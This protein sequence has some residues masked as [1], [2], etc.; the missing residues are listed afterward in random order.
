MT[1]H[2]PYRSI[3]LFRMLLAAT[4][5]LFAVPNAGFSQSLDT[6]TLSGTVTDPE[7]AVVVGAEVELVDTATNQSRKQITNNAGQYLFSAVPPGIYTLTV[8]MPGFRQAVIPS[9]KVEVAKSYTIDVTLEVGEMV[10][11]VEV[12]AGVGVELQ[13]TDATVGNVIGG[14]VLQV[15]TNLKR[16]ATTLLLF[17]PTVMP[18]QGVS[19]LAGGQ[20]AGARSDQ[21]TFLLDGGE[22]TSNVEGTGGYNTG[23]AGEPRAVIPTPVESLEEFR[24]TTNNPTATFGRSAGGQVMMVTKRGTNEIHG[25]AYWYHQNDNL[26]ANTWDFNRTGVKKPELKDNRFGF[27]LGGPLIKNKTFLFGHYEGRR[28][29]RFSTITRLVPTETLRQGILRF[30]DATGNIVSYDLTTAALCGDGTQLCDPRGLGISPVVRAL[31]NLLPA[32]NDP[33]L[34]DGLNTIGF[35][36]AA[37]TALNE[38]FAVVRLDHNFSQNWRFMASYRYARTDE[39]DTSQIDIAGLVSG[40][41]GKAV[42]VAAKP[43]EPRYVVAGLTGSLTPRLTNDF[44]FSWYRHWW[45]WQRTSPF[46]QVPG[47]RGALQL[48]GE[49]GLVDEPINIDTQ[50]A[51]SRVWNGRVTVISDNLTWVRGAHTIQLGGRFS[52]DN[53]IHSRNDKVIGSLSSLVYFVDAAGAATIPDTARPPTCSDTVTTNCLTAGDV[54][55]W[56]SLYAAVLGI[57]DNA[58]ILITR[59]SQLRPKPLGTPLRVDTTTRSFDLFASDTWR[60]GPSFTVTYGLSWSVQRPITERDGLQTVMIFKENGQI[61]EGDDYFQRRREAALKGEIF[62]PEL[63]FVPI[64]QSGRSRP[65]DTDWNNLGPRIAAAWNPSFRSGW[66]GRLFGDGRT[67]FRGGYSLTYDRLN[68][69]GLVMIPILGVGFGQTITC[70]GPRIDGTCAGSNDPSNAFRIGVDGDTV[71]LPPAPEGKVPIEVSTPFGEILSFQID[72]GLKV[73]ESHTIDFTIQRELP[74]NMLLE[75]GYVGRFGRNLQQSVDLNAAPFFHI[76]PASGQSFAEAFDAVATALRT[77]QP[78]TPQPWFENLLFPGAT[79]SLAANFTSQ[80]INGAVTSMWRTG[81]DLRARLANGLQPFN[82]LQMLINWLRV[83]GGRSNYHAGFI[84]LRKRMSHGLFF[85]INYTFSHSLDQLG[86]NQ[87]FI[88]TNASPFDFDINYGPSLFDRRHTLSALWLYEL[89]FG[90]GRRFSTGRWADKVFGGWYISGIFTAN[91]GLPLCVA[92]GGGVWG[93]GSFNTQCAIPV[94]KPRFGNSVH[95][96]VAGSGGV[97]TTG[98]PAQGGSGLNLFAD[99]EAVFNNF[100]RA[101]ISQD[102][103]DGRGVLRGQARWNMDLSLGKRT[104][105][106]ETVA[107]RFSFDFANVFNHVEFEDPDLTLQNPSTFGVLRS[108][109]NQPRFIQFGLRFEF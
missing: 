46:P 14:E 31:W 13:T 71:P 21:N 4:L 2:L 90:R 75:M 102:R 29:P 52:N 72:T 27:S 18:G 33:T 77:G 28:F 64:N 58:S 97:G 19:T 53:T 43:L 35:R 91:S 12:T 47:T 3:S 66:L 103:R 40:Q 89:P 36:A 39:P 48:A 59:D 82:N 63:A 1:Q 67:V 5:L 76:D 8:T 98:D 44:R 96:G 20:V 6:A 87:Q 107:V 93:G 101:L 24:V 32:G 88:G 11:T 62:N 15:L 106:T 68:G 56:N 70:Q 108:Q 16:D 26:N 92:Q 73:G 9:L 17:Q 95:S 79:E 10:E 69:V 86:F 78:V 42:A 100:R 22:V 99:P 41:P 50:R 23:Q 65:Y 81:I 109:F 85:D 84:S 45:E 60:V 7:G 55:R 83:D 80:F 34:G 61:L 104:M 74:G 37:S 49:P 105:I 30:R 57:V 25:S 38:D 94:S 54:S 51:R